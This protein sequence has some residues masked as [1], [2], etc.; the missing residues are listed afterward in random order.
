MNTST[1]D[2]ALVGPDGRLLRKSGVTYRVEGTLTRAEADWYRKMKQSEFFLVKNDGSE[3]G[4]RW[5]C[6]RC[7]AS[8][9]NA[10]DYFTAYC[11]E[12]P[13]R[14]LEHALF[15]YVQASHDEYLR[16]RLLRFI[17]NLAETDRAMARSLRAR[18]PGAEFY[19]IAMGVAVPIT[20][21][22][23]RGF[24]DVMSM[25]SGYTITL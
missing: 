1:I 5:R 8:G 16:N 19:A 23:A 10:H 7:G 12:L 9:K 3:T 2:P 6:G 18:N 22:E 15:S 24:M 4:E 21:E 13:Y 11:V 17:P 14:G 20:A 25:R